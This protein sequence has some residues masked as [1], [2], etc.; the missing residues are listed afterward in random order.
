MNEIHP[1]AIIGTQV[2]IGVNNKILPYT[3]IDGPIEIGD[4]NV[5]GPHAVI[6]CPATDTKKNVIDVN[7]TTVRIGNN[8]IIREFCVVEQPCYETETIIE[9]NVFVMQG[10][11]ISHDVLLQ[12]HVVVTNTSVL[13]GI[14]KILKGAN[15]AMACT[16]NQYITIGHYS[17]VATGAACMKN[18]K[19][20][21]RY[22]PNKP[23]SVNK[24]AIQKYGFQEYEKEITN[25]VLNNETVKS[26]IL[27]DIVEEFDFWV[28]KYKKETYV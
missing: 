23:M 19:P 27:K 13:A 6:G 25:Y 2:K 15:I 22:I 7:K 21:S 16:I 24:Y 26:P 9:N 10:A 5:I 17:I 14:V 4:N 28:A 20:F 11:H 3:I 8:N 12:D 1:T 18:V